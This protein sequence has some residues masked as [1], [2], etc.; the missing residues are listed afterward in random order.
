MAHE[1]ATMFYNR[2]VPWHGLGVRVEGAQSAE[3][4]IVLAGLNYEVEQRPIMVDGMMIDGYKANVKA[5]DGICV[6]VVSDRYKPLQNKEAFDFMDSLLGKDVKYETAGALQN[7]KKVWMLACLEGRKVLDDE[8]IPYMVLSNS[9][10][11]KGSIK[12]AMTPV[13]VVC[14]NTLNMAL[15]GANRMYSTKHVGDMEEKKHTAQMVLGFSRKYM[16]AFSKEAENLALIHVTKQ[17][18]CKFLDSLFPIDEDASDRQKVNNDVLRE[19]VTHAYNMKDLGNHR[20]TAWGILNAVSDAITH[21]TPQRKT[22]TA[23]ENR[24][25]DVADGHKVIDLAYAL[26]KKKQK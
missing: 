5:N 25:A 6:G 15:G 20:G 3:Q 4:A 23:R 10:D 8:V 7:F 17:E 26:L 12:V 14:Q 13:R 22:A 2:E 19:G 16:E 24:F 11:G 9:F 1:V 21:M 18:Y